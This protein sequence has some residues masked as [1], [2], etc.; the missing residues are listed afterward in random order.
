VGIK[1]KNHSLTVLTVATVLATALFGFLGPQRHQDSVQQAS[2]TSSTSVTLATP[3]TVVGPMGPS[4]M[5]GEQG[6]TGAIGP[7]GPIGAKGAQGQ[8]GPIGA[9]GPIGPQ[10]PVGPTGPRG[11]QGIQGSQGVPGGFGDFGAFYDT[12]T[13]WLPIN[14][15]ISIPFNQTDLSSGVFTAN[16][17]LGKPTQIRFTTAGTYNVA[18]SSQ[19]EKTDGGTDVV[20]IWLAKNGQNV[21]YTSTDVYLTNSGIKSRTFAAWN[22]FVKVE[23]GDF[24]QLK[25]SATNDMATSILA[26]PAQTNPS[27]PAIPSTIITV[28]QVSI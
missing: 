22:F 11:E 5:Q 25:I 15:A 10:G 20:S 28:N 7:Q 27:R 23:V 1:I 24:I 2:D 26:S 9:T 3:T 21:D 8:T 19:L 17:E 16:D 13:V 4:G 12:T 18:F 6:E 14:E